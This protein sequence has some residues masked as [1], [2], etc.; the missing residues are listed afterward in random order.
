MSDTMTRENIHS[1]LSGLKD[2]AKWKNVLNLRF[3]DRKTQ[4]VP[5]KFCLFKRD[6][7]FHTIINGLDGVNYAFGS[8]ESWGFVG[9]E[10]LCFFKL[11]RLRQEYQGELYDR[12]EASQRLFVQGRYTG[13]KPLRLRVTVVANRLVLDSNWPAPPEE[14]IPA[15]PVDYGCACNCDNIDL[16][17]VV[18]NSLTFTPI[19][20]NVLLK[21][22]SVTYY[23]TES[24][25]TTGQYV[26]GDVIPGVYD[27]YITFE[28]YDDYVGSFELNTT[29]LIY[30]DLVPTIPSIACGIIFASGGQ[31]YEEHVI[32]LGTDLG[33]VTL[34]Y[35]TFTVP[36]RFVVVWNGVDVIGNVFENPDLLP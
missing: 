11:W 16:T 9:A 32:N 28:G 26:I 3:S 33:I 31:G 22:G 29:Q 8:T 24:H 17:G 10:R 23:T 30:N 25:P 27:I 6:A 20:T 34:T 18:R 2:D 5:R 7:G 19:G 4:V 13:D 12:S 35:D 14:P 1:G 21:Q 15:P 36:D